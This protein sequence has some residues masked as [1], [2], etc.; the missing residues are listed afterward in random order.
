MA[1]EAEEEDEEE[2]VLAGVCKPW[3]SAGVDFCCPRHPI[4]SVSN[5]EEEEREEAGE[6]TILACVRKPWSSVGLSCR[7]PPHA[8]MF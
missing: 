3:S 2:A 7:C 5:E 8:K 4:I 1:N 6:Q